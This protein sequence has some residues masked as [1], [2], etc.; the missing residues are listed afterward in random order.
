[1]GVFGVIGTFG[2]I[3]SFME[4]LL[5]II[6][7]YFVITNVIKYWSTS[8]TSLYKYTKANNF[9]DAMVNLPG[10]LTVSATSYVVDASKKM[11][12]TAFN[13]ILNA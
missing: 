3:L 5:I 10:A 7:V 11:V 6:V 4:T 1:M 2:S 9:R 12:T 8:K 13:E